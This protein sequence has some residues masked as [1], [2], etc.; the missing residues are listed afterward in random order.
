MK[1]E[2][3][4]TKWPEVRGYPFAWTGSGFA[5]LAELIAVCWTI[6]GTACCATQCYDRV[7]PRSQT[8][9]LNTRTPGLMSPVSLVASV[10]P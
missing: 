6:P 3:R 2:L 4:R 7:P 9:G 10:S 1:V 5:S 8:K